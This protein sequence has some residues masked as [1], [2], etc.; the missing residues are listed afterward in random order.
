MPKSRNRKKKTRETISTNKKRSLSSTKKIKQ[1]KANFKK[2]PYSNKWIEEILS[3]SFLWDHVA[4][5]TD[6][7]DKDIDTMKMWVND[8]NDKDGNMAMALVYENCPSKEHQFIMKI[9]LLSMTK[10]QGNF[11]VYEMMNNMSIRKIDGVNLI[12]F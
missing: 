7:I 12:S 4:N 3:S 1:L 6:V 5:V 11:A 2:C 10:W 9:A 8:P